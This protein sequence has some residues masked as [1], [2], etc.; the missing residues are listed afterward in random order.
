[1]DNHSEQVRKYNMSR[2]KRSDTNPE[3]LV[4]RFLF[5]QGF[6]Y[7][8]DVKTMPGHPDIVLTKYKTVVFVNGC[9]WHM[10][11]GCKKFVLPSSN[12]DYW[13][14]KLKGNR[15]RDIKNYE[16]L[17]QQGWKVVTIWECE[18]HKTIVNVTLD[19][20]RDTILDQNRTIGNKEDI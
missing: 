6:R 20:L 14:K 19:R 4:R 12:S 5:S 8:K 13:E 7:R 11:E 9:F 18:L 15:Q 10:H 3:L 2:I 1:M 17:R 16:M